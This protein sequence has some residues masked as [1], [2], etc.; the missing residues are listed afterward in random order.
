[1]AVF[2]LFHSVSLTGTDEDCDDPIVSLVRDQ[3]EAHERYNVLFTKQDELLMALNDTKTIN[4]ASY[5]VS[6]PNDWTIIVLQ[7]E[8]WCELQTLA[9][10]YDDT[11]TINGYQRCFGNGVYPGIL[12]LSSY[13]I[14]TFTLKA[15]AAATKIRYL[16]AVACLSTDAR[17]EAYA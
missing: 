14:T 7:V 13:N 15:L 10:N 8:G 11:S 12:V 3:I 4:L 5:S 2:S 6:Y 9:K 17:Y 1:M 16:A